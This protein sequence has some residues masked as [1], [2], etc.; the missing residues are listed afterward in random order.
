MVREG[1]MEKENKNLGTESCGNIDTLYINKIIN[2]IMM[3][4]IIIIITIF[5]YS[6]YYHHHHHTVSTSLWFRDSFISNA[7]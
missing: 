1:R 7:N 5:Y 2:F 6:Y 4:I 3:M